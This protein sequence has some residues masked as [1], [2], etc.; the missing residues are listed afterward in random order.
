MYTQKAMYLGRIGE[1][2]SLLEVELRRGGKTTH[3]DLNRDLEDVFCEVLNIILGTSLVNLNQESGNFPGVDLGDRANRFAVQVTSRADRKKVQRTLDIFRQPFLR[4]DYDRLMV[5]VLGS[6]PRYQKPFDTEGVELEI[7]DLDDLHLRIT[8]LEMEKIRRVDTELRD[9]LRFILKAGGHGEIPEQLPN[10]QRTYLRVWQD[11]VVTG[12]DGSLT[13]KDLYIPNPFVQGNAA[14]QRDDLFE[15]LEM[16]LCADTEGEDAVIVEGKQCTGKSTMVAGILE[17]A[18]RDWGFQPGKVHL[19]SFGVRDLRNRALSVEALRDYL[20][21]QSD[22]C[23]S[24]GLLIIDALDESDWS[25]RHAQEQLELL[26]DD[27]AAYRCKLIATVRE[28]YLDFQNVPGVHRIVLQPFDIEHAQRWMEIF[29]KSD[30][31]LDIRAQQENLLRIPE[32]V[33]QMILLPHVLQICMTHGISLGNVVNLNRLY[34]LVFRGPDGLLNRDDYLPHVREQH[35]QYAARLQTAVKIAVRCMKQ[36][37]FITQEELKVYAPDMHRFRT[38]Y[39][40]E[41]RGDGYSFVHRSIPAYLIA[42]G[43]YDAYERE[44]TPRQCLEALRP[45]VEEDG[46]LSGD[47]ILALEQMSTR[48]APEPAER[49]QRL[50]LAFLSEELEP[51]LVEPTDRLRN[52]EAEYGMWFKGLMR[53]L[54]ALRAPWLDE[55]GE[56]RF[57]EMLSGEARERFRRFF[58]Q[59]N[60]DAGSWDHVQSCSMVNVDLS[61][62]DLG[63]VCLN[64][65]TIERVDLRGAGFGRSILRNAY[66]LDSNLCAA[67]FDGAICSGIQFCGCTLCG[68][69]FYG[70]DLRGARFVD[71]DLSYADLRGADLGKVYFENCRLDGILLHAEQLRE[72]LA[73]LDLETIRR[74]KIRLYWEDCE[75]PEEL[76]E[77]E[78]RRQ[79]PVIHAIRHEKSVFTGGNVRKAEKVRR[80]LE[81]QGTVTREELLAG[82]PGISRSTIQQAISTLIQNK[83]IAKSGGGRYIVYTWLDK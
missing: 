54:F 27:L 46:V 56:Q 16:I 63:G 7:L 42:L 28:N 25:A 4:K 61:G 11:T 45:I 22:D 39:L 74:C 59:R 57:F 21:L 58:N 72:H 8:G 73:L 77:D 49:A 66:I 12:K 51:L 26:L 31:S 15:W 78:Y 1:V 65:K 19:L 38:E 9:G 32:E 71:C 40:L 69:S 76:V 13:R 82:C 6:K 18:Y 52:M 3:Y 44:Q 81:K 24:D 62:L 36:D 48:K 17:R 23:F 34:E 55:K 53:L 20:N 75:L 35:R 83:T 70:A 43:L 29:G 68:A 10:L 14:E 64:R 30:R 79:R 33:R 80:F 37:N 5:L 41:R 50:F 67:G 2:F 60:R 47:V